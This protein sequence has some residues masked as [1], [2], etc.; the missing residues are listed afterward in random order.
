MP[1]TEEEMVDIP[2]EGESVNIEVNQEEVPEELKT[3]G[4]E[5]DES[6]EEHQDYSKKFKN[7][8]I[9]LLEKLKK[10]KGSRKRL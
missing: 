2:S 5:S 9:N 7:V 10:Q 4:V 3:A 8:L 1:E 6:D